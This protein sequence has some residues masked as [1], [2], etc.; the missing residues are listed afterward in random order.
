MILKRL[1]YRQSNQHAKDFFPFS[2]PI[3]TNSF[4]LSFTSPMTI[5]VR[6]NGS[7][8]STLIE[9]LAQAANLIELS[10]AFEEYGDYDLYVPL[11]ARLT[12]EWSV[13]ERKGLFFRADGFDSFIRQ[14]NAQKRF[15]QEELARI[16]EVDPKSLE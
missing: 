15:A 16:D 14:V 13:K 5:F 6:E 2:L 3:F 4:S 11:V 8:K 10:Q 9:S 12:L 1:H 7:G